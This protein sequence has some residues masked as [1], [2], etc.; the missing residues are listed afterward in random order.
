MFLAKLGWAAVAENPELA[1][2]KLECDINLKPGLLISSGEITITHT[3]ALPLSVCTNQASCTD[4]RHEKWGEPHHTLPHKINDSHL[5]ARQVQCQLWLDWIQT[6]SASR[7]VLFLQ[8]L[9]LIIRCFYCSFS[10]LHLAVYRVANALLFNHKV[11]KYTKSHKEMFRRVKM[12]ELTFCQ[13]F[14]LTGVD[15]ATMWLYPCSMF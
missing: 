4:P 12:S 10:N 3:L 15:K 7:P 1:E 13:G 8:Y 2:F 9:H 14:P 5:R 6:F 11:T